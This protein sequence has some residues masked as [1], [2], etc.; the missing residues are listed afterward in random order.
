MPW[1]QD[2]QPQTSTT[3]ADQVAF[4][5]ANAARRAHSN[6]MLATGV[7]FFLIGLVITLVTYSSASSGRGGGTYIVAWG[8]M[9]FGVIRI[10]RGLASRA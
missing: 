7:V 3:D 8:P 1:P 4:E 10:F 5:R 6:R 2:P 9:V